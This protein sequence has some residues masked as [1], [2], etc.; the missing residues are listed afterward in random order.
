[1]DRIQRQKVQLA[2]RAGDQICRRDARFLC[3]W[4]NCTPTLSAGGVCRSFTGTQKVLDL[5]EAENPPAPAAVPDPTPCRR[6]SL[7]RRSSSLSP[8]A[9]RR[10]GWSPCPERRRQCCRCTMEPSP[11]IAP[12][13]APL[14]TTPPASP[15]PIVYRCHG[16]YSP[17]A[18]QRLRPATFDG[19]GSA[20][21]VRDADR[22][23]ARSRSH[24]LPKYWQLLYATKSPTHPFHF[25][26]GSIWLS[27]SAT[28]G[29]RARTSS[30]SSVTA[31][32]L[33]PRQASSLGGTP[34][35]K[36]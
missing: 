2:A 31:C 21:S 34:R 35:P 20:R 15:T 10:N 33:T 27:T 1:M 24:P 13:P 26:A 28:P 4:K 18:Q 3:Q 29:T 23:G 30:S 12:P 19:P 32:L 8:L 11:R 9:R 5:G 7:R 36:S 6:L 14:P 17:E 22:Y 25:S 16:V